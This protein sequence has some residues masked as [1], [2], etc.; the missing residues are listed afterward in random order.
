M[1]E[2][3][4]RRLVDG[5]ASRFAKL[6]AT[7]G[8]ATLACFKLLRAFRMLIPVFPRLPSGDLTQWG[9]FGD[10][11]GGIWG[12]LISIAALIIIGLTWRSSKKVERRSRVLAVL[13]EMLKTHDLITTTDN[14]HF[15]SRSGP[16]SVL[17]R[18]FAAIYKILRKHDISFGQ[19]SINDRID[20]AYTFAFFG[21]S[22]QARKALSRFGPERIKLINDQISKFGGRAEG[23]YKGLFRGH[24]TSVSQYMRTLYSMYRFIDDSKL[25][26][27]EKID[28]G[29]IVKS[30]LSNFE[31]AMIALNILSHLGQK[32]ET[33]G[34][35]D[36]YKPISNI[37]D[38]FFGFDKE[39]DITSMFPHVLFEWQSSSWTPIDR[40]IFD[41]GFARI[42]LSFWAK[43]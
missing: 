31:Q 36:K 41:V 6:L 43:K 23:R 9:Q 27:S 37:P 4:K 17:L 13:S 11:I 30:K 18:E 7:R 29:K 25:D 16:P 35:V 10:Y 1:R 39:F 5:I 42:S 20:I 33:N 38:A 8:D 34:I 3:R 24:Q 19:T 2:Q 40:R 14:M 12:T 26:E 22:E 32:W 21:V 28:L 15:I